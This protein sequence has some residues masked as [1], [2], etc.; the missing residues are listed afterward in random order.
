MGTVVPVC[1]RPLGACSRYRPIPIARAMKPK[2]VASPA[3]NRAARGDSG[4]GS[5]NVEL[6]K[7][8]Q[9]RRRGR[10]G[11]LSCAAPPSEPYRRISR[12]RLSSR[13]RCRSHGL[14]ACARAATQEN[15]PCSVKKAFASLHPCSQGRQHALRPDARL[16]PRLRGACLCRQSSPACAGLT[17]P[18]RFSS[19]VATGN[20]GAAPGFAISPQR[21]LQN[22][23]G[24][25]GGRPSSQPAS[26][27]IRPA[28]DG[29]PQGQG[30]LQAPHPVKN[31]P[32]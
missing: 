3:T 25:Y 26:Q 18:P 28:G 30:V 4:I 20:P 19:P 27:S 16:R 22:P 15:S 21:R 12:I 31:N 8:G 2:G 32:Q 6:G 9:G 10:D 1:F 17:P 14:T 7:I 29:G 11:A 24:R 13:W 23:D 5:W